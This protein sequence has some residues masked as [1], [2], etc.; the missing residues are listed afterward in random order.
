M[1]RL[2]ADSPQ[3]KEGLEWQWLTLDECIGGK[4]D[5]ANPD[6]FSQMS[7]ENKEGR[8]RACWN[9]WIAPHN[10]EGFFLNMRDMLV[11]AGDW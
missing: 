5:R 8:K 2:S 9:S 4:I 7:T 11:K 3:F 10:L 1:S 6:Y